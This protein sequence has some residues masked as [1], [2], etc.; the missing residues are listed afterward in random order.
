MSS[1]FLLC[2][3]YFKEINI[4]TFKCKTHFNNLHLQTDM[5]PKR[6]YS[7]CLEQQEN[8]RKLRYSTHIT[9]K[10][11][12]LAAQKRIPGTQNNKITHAFSSKIIDSKIIKAK[13]KILSP[14]YSSFNLESQLQGTL[15]KQHP[16]E[17]MLCKEA[18]DKCLQW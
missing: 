17:C 9:Q 14:Y 13:E 18:V 3:F 15:V 8:N 11:R 12:M 7:R 16:Q 2:F 6:Q 4:S 1:Q 5:N 10:N